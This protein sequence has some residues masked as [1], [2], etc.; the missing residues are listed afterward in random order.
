[1]D[2]RSEPASEKQRRF[3][4]HLMRAAG[5]RE[6]LPAVLTK[7][8]A[9]QLINELER[10]KARRPDPN[11]P[12]ATCGHSWQSHDTGWDA[13]GCMIRDCAGCSRFV[14]PEPNPHD[15]ALGYH[16]DGSH[17]R[18]VA[19]RR[20]QVRTALQ[21]ERCTLGKGK[22]RRQ[23]E[24]AH[25]GPCGWVN[26]CWNCGREGSRVEGHGNPRFRLVTGGGGW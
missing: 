6:P 12:C 9:S 20:C 22:T 16:P 14:E 13:S 23:G 26:G 1:M 3:L 24:E 21:G 15:K 4:T 7:A 8:D 25:P 2:W 19:C 10:A 17:L 11:R 5:Q 18:V